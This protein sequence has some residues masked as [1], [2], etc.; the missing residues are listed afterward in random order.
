M[1][2]YRL[3]YQTITNLNFTNFIGLNHLF[4]INMIVILY[5]K[6]EIIVL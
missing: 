2:E 3:W 4:V 6:N 1:I 5:T